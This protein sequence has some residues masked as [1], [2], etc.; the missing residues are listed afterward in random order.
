MKRFAKQTFSSY[1]I[2]V[3]ILFATACLMSMKPEN[4]KME[5]IETKEIVPGIYSIK[6][7]FVNLFIIRDGDSYVVI[8]A[9]SNQKVIAQEM[10]SLKINPD[11]VE[12]ILLTHTHP[13]HIAAIGLFKNA[14]IYLSANELETVDGLK[15]DKLKLGKETYKNEFS[16]VKHQQ[17]IRFKA[18]SIQV[19]STPGHTPGS[20]SYL[21][22][23]NYLFV[24]DAFS[25][26]N[27]KVDKPNEIYTKD[28]KIAI[29]SFENI[30]NLPLAEFI[31]TAHTGYTN[32]YKN[33]VKTELK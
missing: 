17:I 15:P 14:H 26:N 19:I 20:T 27:G 13:D 23:R 12:A 32:D 7:T 11:K 24:G 2:N 30:N 6:D 4:K 28:M 25:L 21:L 5:P 22:N 16:F 33:A 18:I 29:E 31:F 10:K 1:T 8:D 9:G 3:F